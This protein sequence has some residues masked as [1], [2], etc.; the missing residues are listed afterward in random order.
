MAD[1]CV[2][3]VVSIPRSQ[4]LCELDIKNC[5]EV[6]CENG[7]DI[8][9]LRSIYISHVAQFRCPTE[10]IMH[11]FTRLE[12]ARR[13]PHLGEWITPDDFSSSFKNSP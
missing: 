13:Y 11:G 12:D 1:D 6:M 4:M 3:L 8:K 7:E 2:K 9:L 10:R 5:K